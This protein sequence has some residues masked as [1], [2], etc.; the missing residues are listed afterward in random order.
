MSQCL[1]ITVDIT[2]RKLAEEERERLLSELNATINSTAI[3]FL[4]YNTENQITRA[5]AAAEELLGLS[6]AEMQQPRETRMAHLRVELPDGRPLMPEA[7]PATRAL[8]GEIVRDTELVLHPPDGRTLWVN[9][10][11]APIRL[12]DGQ[13]LGVVQTFADITALH[14]LQ[15]Q[16]KALMQMVSHDLRAP[17]AVIKGHGQVVS[18]LLGERHIDGLLQ[19][20]MQAIDRGVDRMN[21]MIQDLVDVTRWEGGQLE[22]K[23]EAVALPRYI[24]DLLQRL[25]TAMEVSRIH[26]EMPTDLPPVSADYARLD[27]ML[28]NLLSNALKYSDPGTPVHV[29]AWR[30]QDSVV[31][32][33]SDQGRGIDPEDLPHLF[34][35]FYRAKGGSKAEGIG[36]GLYITRVLVE[37][38]GGQIW[39]DSEVGKGSSFYITL[40]IARE[41]GSHV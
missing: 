28:V 1:G 38:H 35:R 34:E 31:L 14:N 7:S 25:S 18:G 21:L 24:A 30:E 10:S 19:Q 11:A 2:D 17:L 3:G 5:N 33:V 16:Q 23:R 9:V 29:R 13:V 36:L 32:A 26:V 22:L 6:L 20:S 41:G 40:P 4:I 15:E 12:P 39:V 37:A 8:R 27:R